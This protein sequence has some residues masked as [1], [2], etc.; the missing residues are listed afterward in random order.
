M[1]KYKNISDFR[2]SLVLKGKRVLLKPEDV[3]ESETEL[4]YVFL[5]PV[6]TSTPVTAKPLENAPKKVDVLEQKLASLEKEKEEIA[7]TQAKEIYDTVEEIDKVVKDLQ[8]KYSDLAG[9]LTLIKNR[10][11][12]TLEQAQKF[13]QTYDN[14]KKVYL[15]RLEMLKSAVM[16][17]ENEVFGTSEDTSGK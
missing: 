6:D 4:K 7:A 3:I 17:I 13:E 8:N 15:R 10:L 1:F 2:Q 5:E 16:T 14:D 12:T 11:D 9:V